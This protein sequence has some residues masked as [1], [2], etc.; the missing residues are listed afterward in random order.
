MSPRKPE[1]VHIRIKLFGAFEKLHHFEDKH[2][3]S[4]F[5]DHNTTLTLTKRA[6]PLIYSMSLLYR[7][8]E[9]DIRLNVKVNESNFV[10]VY[11]DHKLY[12]SFHY[13]ERNNRYDDI[14]DLIETRLRK[15][16]IQEQKAK[17]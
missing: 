3:F 7:W 16:L 17:S 9:T 8:Q 5:F 1:F 15:Q 10:K 14:I 13:D 4:V 11:R 12:F 2:D 6:L